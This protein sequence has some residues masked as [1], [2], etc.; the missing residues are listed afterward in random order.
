M[1]WFIFGIIFAGVA[2]VC[3]VLYKAYATQPERE[4]KRRARAGDRV[5]ALL[6]RTVAYG[7]SA[8]IVVTVVGLAALY[9]ATVFMSRAVGTA[10]G[11]LA[12]AAI[13]LLG[14]VFV[15]RKDGVHPSA[16]WLA[17]KL[18]PA[19]AWAAER[20]MP[21]LDRLG[22][23]IRR[24][25]PIHFHT[26]MYEKSDLVELLNAQKDQPDSRIDKHEIH[27]LE[28]A[29]TFG[30]KTVAEAMT[31]RRAVVSA[32]MDT[33]VGPVLMGE[34]HASGHSRFP[35]TGT[36]KDHIEGILYLRDL[37]EV[38]RTGTVAKIMR[39]KPI[40]VHEDFTLFQV[41]Q[42]FLKTKQHMFIVVNE[43]EEYVGIITIEDV[44]ERVIGKVIIDEFDRYD[45]LRAVAALSARSEHAIKQK[46]GQDAATHAD[47]TD[48]PPPD[49]TTD[50]KEV[51]K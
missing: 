45:D 23:A 32:Q 46:D 38:K 31:P 6:Y 27:L 29:L 7:M 49:A 18:S 9:L 14:A 35:V 51:V 20:G 8:Q 39:T 15:R 16:V 33:A 17:A 43:F 5:A 40:Y 2:A 11:L 1:T 30:D 21:V 22:R 10:L 12:V 44:L 42:A 25:L 26:G 47:A 48:I 36:S 34:L 41:L 37:I 28:N 19:V 13:V 50:A 24:L 3:L 4:L